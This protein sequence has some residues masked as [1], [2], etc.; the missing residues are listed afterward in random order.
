[1]VFG[2]FTGL[3]ERALIKA[4]LDSLCGGRVF[5]NAVPDGYDFPRDENGGVLPYIVLRFA[6][7]VTSTVGRNVA[8]GEQDQ[9]H[10]LSG[11][12]IACGDDDDDLEAVIADCL[13]E[14]VGFIP[15]ENCTAIQARG[16]TAWPQ[17][18][19]ANRPTRFQRSFFIRLIVNL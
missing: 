4:R 6:E 3:T 16:G 10:L 8:G 14:L 15:T 1:M 12:V 13:R 5:K 17:A 11:T 19:A 18:A 9:P 2:D 7:P